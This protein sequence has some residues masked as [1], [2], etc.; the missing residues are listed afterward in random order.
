MSQS[1]MIEIAIY[2]EG[3]EYAMRVWPAVPRVCDEIMVRRMEPRDETHNMINRPQVLDE[4][5]IVIV[6]A[7]CWGTSDRSRESPWSELR[8]SL[9]C[10][11]R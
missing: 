10:K 5:A 6:E 9:F 4:H 3:A 1:P 7:V 2:I 11:W 8:V